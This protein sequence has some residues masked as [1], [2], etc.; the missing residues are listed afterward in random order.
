MLPTLEPLASPPSLIAR[1]GA[2][3]SRLEVS[4]AFR[5]SASPMLR[6]LA[7]WA[8]NSGDRVCAVSSAFRNPS[9]LSSRA[10]TV[11]GSTCGAM[12]GACVAATGRGGSGA[13]RVNA[14]TSG[15]ARGV[16]AAVGSVM[17]FLSAT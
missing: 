12:A 10:G 14:L 9:T 8:A 15:G 11:A 17:T 2:C 5:M 7:A 3:S 13:V 1:T 4:A 6:T 16:G